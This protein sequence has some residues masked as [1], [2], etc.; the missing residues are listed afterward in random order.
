MKSSR[1]LDHTKRIQ[2]YDR[3]NALEEKKRHDDSIGEILKPREADSGT[4]KENNKGMTR[5]K[6][7]DQEK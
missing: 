1:L 6:A 3:H 2:H 4:R 5:H 7:R